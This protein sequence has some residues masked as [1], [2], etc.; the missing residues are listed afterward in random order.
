[1]R[2]Y[3]QGEKWS[4]YLPIPKISAFFFP[5]E[6][7]AFLSFFTFNSV[8]LPSIHLLFEVYAGVLLWGGAIDS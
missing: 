7:Q 3:E 5:R 8:A 1:M 6:L 2:W 4:R